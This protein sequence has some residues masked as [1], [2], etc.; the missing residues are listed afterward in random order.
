VT[1]ADYQAVAES[2]GALAAPIGAGVL[3]WAK[4]LPADLTSWSRVRT[5]RAT[6][7][8]F[9]REVAA[10][11]STEF[12]PEVSLKAGIERDP[13]GLGPG[14][15]HAVRGVETPMPAGGLESLPAEVIGVV[16][17]RER[18]DHEIPRLDARDL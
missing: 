2:V 15:A 9:S 3:G 5:R 14:A 1:A 17:P 10:L 11:P 4:G 18:R 8:L 6:S 7:L 16:R 13:D 12:N